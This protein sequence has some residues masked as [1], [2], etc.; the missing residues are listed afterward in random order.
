MDLS[1]PS[2][3]AVSAHE[4]AFWYSPELPLFREFSW[5]VKE[6][7]FWSVVGPSGCGK[8]T[9]L[10]LLAGLRRPISGEIRIRG[11]VVDGPD[12]AVGLMLQDYGLLPWLTAYDN[13]QLGLQIRGLSRA[14][15]SGI[16]AHWLNRLGIGAIAAQLPHQLSGGQRQRVA[17]ARVLS[18]QP[19]VLLLD[20]PFS[21]VDEMMREELQ[22]LL[23]E[24]KG[25][26]GATVI[27]V[28]HNV[29]EAILLSQYVLI[30]SHH[31]PVQTAVV[32]STGFDGGMPDRTD[33]AFQRLRAQVREELAQ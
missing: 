32:L 17:L 22:V 23:W 24:L 20:E 19:A 15:R 31:S 5:K 3:A 33:P 4:L 7:E 13:V 11:R 6:G 26:I 9:L 8:T 18:L 29:E 25:E 30:L 16:T 28:T 21:S 2:P 27:F 14:Q 10:H 12:A 1:C